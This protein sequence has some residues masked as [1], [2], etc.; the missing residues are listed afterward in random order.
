MQQLKNI[1]EANEKL[2]TLAQM[3][4]RMKA[5]AS[6]TSK[7][8]HREP[9]PY[10]NVEMIDSHDNSPS[11]PYAAHSTEVRTEEE[12]KVNDIQLKLETGTATS[13]NPVRVPFDV[14]DA[15]FEDLESGFLENTL[16]TPLEAGDEAHRDLLFEL[17]R[18]SAYALA[19]YSHLLALYMRPVT[20]LC[21]LCVARCVHVG[22]KDKTAYDNL[23][24]LNRGVCGN[25]VRPR[26]PKSD[27][28]CG[29][30]CCL[31]C[32]APKTLRL[33]TLDE[34]LHSPKSP[35]PE[36]ISDLRVIG[37]NCFKV[38]ETGMLHL[39]RG[40]NNAELVYASFRNDNLCKPYAIFEGLF[41]DGS[42]VYQ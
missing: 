21:A 23:C 20:G 37:D 6:P 38:N 18:Y 13:P 22:G 7:L 33:S 12:T 8:L 2:L 39:S 24:C 32:C 40:K 16:S 15:D 5:H 28:P 4:S 14:T 11:S 34:R 30:Y 35:S 41:S 26:G 31:C 1:D 3:R 42:L 36:N 27:E 9:S 25:C 10:S 19:S 17:Y 29:C